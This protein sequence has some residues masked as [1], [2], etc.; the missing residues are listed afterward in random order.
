[1]DYIKKWL[2]PDKKGEKN[3]NSAEREHRRG[4]LFESVS[5]PQKRTTG[6]SDRRN[7]ARASMIDF[8]PRTQGREAT[9]AYLD[10][11]RTSDLSRLLSERDRAEKLVCKGP[12][13]KAN[14]EVQDILREPSIKSVEKFYRA[15]KQAELLVKYG[16]AGEFVYNFSKSPSWNK[17]N[18]RRF[19]S[20]QL[21]EFRMMV[22][23]HSVFPGNTSNIPRSPS[24]PI[25][26]VD[27]GT[28]GS[29]ARHDDNR[30]PSV[31]SEP[32]GWRD[33]S[34]LGRNEENTCDPRS[35]STA[36]H[37]NSIEDEWEVE[38]A[39]ILTV[40]KVPIRQVRITSQKR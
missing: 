30:R 39:Q 17:A 25:K 16:I 34:S 32:G 7:A 11:G 4:S 29:T 21:R 9:I 38:E 13:T 23:R 40:T 14:Q 6:S 1:M 19:P 28:S 31:I 3:K 33:M 12:K 36:A 24:T 22:K 8:T 27:L 26:W 2:N 5:T 18:I 20:L 35:P 37:E 10:S 15:C